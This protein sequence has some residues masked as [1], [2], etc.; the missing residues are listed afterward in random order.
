MSCQPFLRF[1]AF[2]LTSISNKYP[3]GSYFTTRL[4]TSPQPENLDAHTGGSNFFEIT[5]KLN[6][7]LNTGTL[8]SQK[9]LYP[10]PPGVP[11]PLD[12]QPV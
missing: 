2:L 8:P 11:P 1:I 4:P 5:Q 9:S 6:K 3:L 12:F 10:L 7:T